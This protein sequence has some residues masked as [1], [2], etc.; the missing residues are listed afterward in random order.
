M[1]EKNMPGIAAAFPLAHRGRQHQSVGLLALSVGYFMVLLD[2]TILN[3]ALPAIEEQLHGS[4]ESL[5]WIVNSYTLVFA[6]LL[7]SGG[8]LGDRYGARRIFCLG[9]AI[10]T[11]A[12]LLCS[13]ALNTNMLIAARALQGVGAA[14]LLP[15]S[16]SLITYLFTERQQQARAVSIWAGIASIA[17]ASGPLLG[18]LLVS[19]LG[20]RSVFLVNIPGGILAL[21]LTLTGV[22]ATPRQDE[23]ALDLAGQICAIVA[24]STLVYGLI[25]WSHVALPLVCATLAVAVLSGTLFVILEARSAHPMLPLQLFRSW[26]VSA[27]MLVALIFQFTFYGL[28]FLFSLFFEQAYGYNAL[29]TG[30][31]FLPQT[32]AC[33]LLLLFASRKLMQWLPPLVSM[34]VSMLFGTAGMLIILLGVHTNFVVIACGEGL[35]GTVAVLVVPPMTNIVLSSVSREHSGIASASL[36]AARQMGGMLAVAILGTALNNPSLF[37]GVQSALFVLIGAFLLGFLLSFSA[38]HFF[39]GQEAPLGV[40]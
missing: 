16:L 27:T 38:G 23:K 6:S 35:V 40:N 10:F 11:G 1:F 13:L 36:N 4:L 17:V 5:Q 7:L 39:G 33:S 15:A 2:S 31:A 12:S 37:A 32:L 25:E 24:C 20:W 9:L 30:F 22:P 34:T 28:F 26:R 8:A 21:I 19:L 18:G 3:V 14:L 29:E